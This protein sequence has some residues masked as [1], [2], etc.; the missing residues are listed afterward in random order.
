MQLPSA[1]WP[2]CQ[3]FMKSQ[4]Y[5]G[6]KESGWMSCWTR[7]IPCRGSCQGAVQCEP[8]AGI[9][10]GSMGKYSIHGQAALCCLL[11]RLAALLK[12]SFNGLLRLV[13]VGHARHGPVSLPGCG[14]QWLS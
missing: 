9:A 8:L 7:M 4:D 14:G 5:Q 1:G 13:F 11:W 2:A 3:Q 12:N 10:G 6:G